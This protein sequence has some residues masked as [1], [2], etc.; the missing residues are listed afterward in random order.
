MESLDLLKKIVSINSV[1][2]QE[3]ELAHFSKGT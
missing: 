3:A 1:F 2:P